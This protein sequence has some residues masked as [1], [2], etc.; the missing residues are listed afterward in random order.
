M[1]KK[2]VASSCACL[3]PIDKK[4]LEEL[5]KGGKANPDVI[6]TL[7]CKTVAVGKFRHENYIRD[8]APYIVDE[9]PALLGDD[10][11]PNPSE[12]VLAALG[13]CLCVGIHANAVAHDIIINKLEIELEGDLNITAV[14]GVGDLSKNKPLG[15][16]DI[17]IKVILDSNA[18]EAKGLELIEHATKYSPVANTLLRPVKIELNG[19]NFKGL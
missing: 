2:V 5:I 4:A 1:E 9:P 13:S 7:K 10:T 16:T 14:W 15:F 12:V 3:S 18:N 6:K 11:A 8:L 17:R 19:K